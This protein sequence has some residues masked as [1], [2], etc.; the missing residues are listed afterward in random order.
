V[1]SW[2]SISERLAGRT[3]LIT[4]GAGG[5]GSATARELARSGARVVVTD[6][7]QEGAAAVAEEL[8]AAGYESRGL[9]LDVADEADWDWVVTE[10]E[11]AFGPV[12]ILHSNAAHKSPDVMRA[13]GDIL[14]VDMDLWDTIMAVNVKA[15]A[16]AC[17]RII[18]GMIDSGGGSI[19]ITSSCSGQTGANR[20]AAYS[21]SKAAVNGLVRQVATAFGKQGVRCNGIAPGVVVTRTNSAL[22][23]DEDRAFLEQAHLTPRLGEPEDIARAVAFL[24]SDDAS[25]ITG[26][27]INVDGGLAAHT[28]ALSSRPAP[29][30][31][32]TAHS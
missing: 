20:L 14:H 8:R 9:R 15:S 7:D 11:A 2:N 26:Q 16:L 21:T 6:V 19:I 28:P 1:A 18:P 17:R 27:I 13:D 3:A 25:F 23:T 22:L 31:E 24:A 10:A 30:V 12:T 29:V 5:I 4:G 32:P